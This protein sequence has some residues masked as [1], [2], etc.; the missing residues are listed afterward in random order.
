MFFLDGDVLS[1]KDFDCTDVQP[2]F[3]A[4]LFVI[5]VCVAMI[6]YSITGFGTRDDIN[7]VKILKIT[8]PEDL[9][10][11]GV[12]DDIMTE[13]TKSCE[14]FSSKTTN[15]GSMY[16]LQYRVVLKDNQKEKEFMDALRCKNGN[17]E[18]ALAMPEVNLNEL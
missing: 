3:N 6:I 2:V 14:L 7:N 13:Y 11:I 4:A 18:V 17:L 16:K 5:M 12:F 8:I 9:D 15:L 1:L 10:Y